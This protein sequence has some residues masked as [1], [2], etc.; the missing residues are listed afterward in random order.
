MQ[1]VAKNGWYL[2]TELAR[3]QKPKE[4]VNN[5]GVQ[6]NPEM[7]RKGCACTVLYEDDKRNFL[8]APLLKPDR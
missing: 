5:T 6:P 1:I 7:T 2:K 8:N 3:R 4:Y